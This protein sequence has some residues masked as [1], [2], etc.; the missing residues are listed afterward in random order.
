ML[1][2]RPL[3]LAIRL[4]R[5]INPRTTATTTK[6]FDPF[7]LPRLGIDRRR[8]LVDRD[9]GGDR[10]REARRVATPRGRACCEGVYTRRKSGRL[11]KRAL[12]YAALL[13]C[14]WAE[15]ATPRFERGVEKRSIKSL[16]Y[17][18]PHS[19]ATPFLQH[20]LQPHPKPALPLAP[21][22]LAHHG[23]P[24][25]AAPRARFTPTVTPVFA[26]GRW[27]PVPVN[28][29][30]RPPLGGNRTRGRETRRD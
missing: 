15:T 6:K 19:S 27:R 11:I 28:E 10:G 4:R 30:A 7:I 9:F 12:V 18:R 5:G 1:L 17:G 16:V 14:R 24:S 22:R 2:L 21:T 26:K 29:F 13:P 3:L 23:P 20:I 25:S 8:L